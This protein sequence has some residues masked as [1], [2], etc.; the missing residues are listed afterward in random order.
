MKRFEPHSTP[1]ESD[2][3]DAA[4]ASARLEISRPTLYA[5]VSRGQ[6][7]SR[8]IAGTRKR[9]YSVSDIDGLLQ[10]KSARRDPNAA[11][12]KTL[13]F[14]GLPVLESELTLIEDG[15][16]FYRGASAIELARSATLEDVAHRLWGQPIYDDA[17]L[18]PADGWRRRW[19][20][21]SVLRR[22]VAYLAEAGGRDVAA[23]QL[24]P[25]A[26]I[27]A[28]ARILRGVAGMVAPTEPSARPIGE[29]LCDAWSVP[30]KHR[31]RIEAALV[32]CADH[33]LNV[34]AFTGRCVASAEADPYFVVTAAVAALAG[35]RHGR[36]SE[37]VAE[38]IDDRG[39]PR[40][41]LERWL[42]AGREIHGLGHP[43]YPAGDPRG[44]M[45]V[46]L[47]LASP[48]KRRTIG[49]ARSGAELFGGAPNLDLG[50]VTLCRSLALPLEAPVC[51]F[52]VGRT[53][54]W[55][56]HAMEQY[57]GVGLIRPRA[58]YVGQ[59]PSPQR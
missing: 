18:V 36:A 49:F 55:L 57:R 2:Y 37:Q 58:R 51:L 56:A 32:L 10:R 20:G 16:L 22:I 21:L 33:E 35:R 17:P 19:A 27:R 8:Q 23:R 14:R 59:R 42:N 26:T 45:L 29:V 31:H 25:S 6:V 54:G 12:V 9:E 43:L 38:L 48:A 53:V 40:K 15:D 13:G 50:L 41:V 5:Y 47:A 34:S 24:Q 52:A 1:G 28:A 3:I 4:T 11:A 30:A 44:R 46:E 7:R 39:S